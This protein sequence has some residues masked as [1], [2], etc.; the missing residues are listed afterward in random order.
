MIDPAPTQ[1]GQRTRERVLAAAT[2]LFAERGFAPVTIRSIGDAAGIDNSSLYRHFES[3]EALALAVI[4]K[5]VSELGGAVGESIPSVPPTFDGIVDAATEVGL[6]LWDRPATA[7][8]ILH[9]MIGWRDEPTGFRLSIPMDD[10]DA[11]AARLFRAFAEAYGEAARRG[12]VRAAAIPEVFVSL[13]GAILLRPAT[14]GSLLQS[15]EPRR[16]AARA[17]EAWR[18]EI[19]RFLRGSLE[20]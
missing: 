19:D 5:A 16:S 14:R 3:K 4:E 7:R 11:P 15:Q 10:P 13:F 6:A 1:H 2:E 18:Q 12:R 17:R 8:L 20:P 9:L